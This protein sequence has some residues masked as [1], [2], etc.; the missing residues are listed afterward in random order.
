MGYGVEGNWG[1]WSK[2]AHSEVYCDPRHH[3][4]DDSENANV[5]RGTLFTGRRSES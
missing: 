2:Y 4:A 3:S 5:H 1:R